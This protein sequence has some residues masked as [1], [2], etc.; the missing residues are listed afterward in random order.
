MRDPQRFPVRIA[1]Q[2]Y[3][4][5]NEKA[6]IRRFLNGQADVVV[7]TTENALLTALAAAWLRVNAWISYVY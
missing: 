5:G 3:E 4:I 6:D 2:G 7:Y 1:M